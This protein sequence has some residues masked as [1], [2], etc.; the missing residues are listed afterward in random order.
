M[1]DVGEVDEA[2]KS[3]T[4][5]ERSAMGPHFFNVA[6]FRLAEMDRKIKEGFVGIGDEFISGDFV[7]WKNSTET[8]EEKPVVQDTAA[9]AAM[10]EGGRLRPP[11]LILDR[12]RSRQSRKHH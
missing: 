2:E 9:E 12:P 8:A 7:N 11:V 3:K 5:E 1:P 10:R 4:W 6:P